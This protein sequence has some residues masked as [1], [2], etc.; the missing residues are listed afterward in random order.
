MGQGPRK[1]RK[2]DA[3]V[4]GWGAPLSADAARRRG[5]TRSSRSDRSV[6][7]AWSSA[8][9]ARR[10]QSGRRAVGAAR[11]G[12]GRPPQGGGRR[13]RQVETVSPPPA[14]RP[15]LPRP[16]PPSGTAPNLSR[17]RSPSAPRASRPLSGSWEEVTLSVLAFSASCAPVVG[18]PECCSGDQRGLT[19]RSHVTLVRTAPL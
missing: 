1:E 17:P 14:P 7:V 12:P 19:R 6:G 8:E 3:G 4:Q 18:T 2:G 10:S 15:A 9:A 16:A 5:R 13:S 11:T